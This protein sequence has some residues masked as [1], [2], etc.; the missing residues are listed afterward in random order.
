MVA[1]ATIEATF[2]NPYPRFARFEDDGDPGEALY[3]TKYIE[4]GNLEFVSSL[5]T[6]LDDDFET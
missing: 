6:A 3:L 4:S 1:I 2:V 5:F